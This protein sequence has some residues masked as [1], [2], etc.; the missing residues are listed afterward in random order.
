MSIFAFVVNAA[1]SYAV[2]ND[3]NTIIIP[4][5]AGGNTIAYSYYTPIDTVNFPFI[6]LTDVVALGVT[7]STF[8]PVIS[9]QMALRLVPPVGIDVSKIKVFTHTNGVWAASGE[10]LALDD[11]Y[12]TFNKATAYPSI[13]GLEVPPGTPRK[14]LLQTIDPGRI[15]SSFP[16]PST[17]WI[18][19][20]GR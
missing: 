7:A 3:G 2:T 20:G 11:T 14:A 19:P 5:Q 10:S 1:T 16:G 13:V 6:P 15:V 4:A 17:G 12:A 18:W 9:M 8:S